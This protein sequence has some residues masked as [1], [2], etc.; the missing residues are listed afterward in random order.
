M[1]LVMRQNTTM[2]K[3][4]LNYHPNNMPLR[5]GIC[6]RPRGGTDI[7]AKSNDDHTLTHTAA[8]QCH[9][10][11]L[12]IILANNDADLSVNNVCGYFGARQGGA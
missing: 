10:T 4:P 9:H 8:Q 11:R 6:Y 3:P 5:I 12:A 7:E 1:A 2:A